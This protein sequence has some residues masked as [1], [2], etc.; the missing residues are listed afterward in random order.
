MAKKLPRRHR[1]AAARRPPVAPSARARVGYKNLVNNQPSKFV[2]D[3]PNTFQVFG[4]SI[5]NVNPNN[6]TVALSATNH[7]W[8][9]IGSPQDMGANGL[10]ITAQPHRK[11]KHHSRGGDDDLTVTIT[12]DTGTNNEECVECTFEDVEY[13]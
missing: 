11:N 12:F 2:E 7:L 9:V 1:A 3:Q 4:D 5:G 8:T 13:I 6:K 10:Q